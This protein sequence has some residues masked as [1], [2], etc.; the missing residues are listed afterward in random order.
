MR[1]IVGKAARNQT[2]QFIGHMRHLEFNPYWNLPASI[3]RAEIIP[4]QSRDAR[5]LADHDM[6]L[7]DARG[8]TH[9][10]AEDG[11]LAA[12]RSG[13]LRVRQRPG[14]QNPLGAVKFALP[15][16]MDIYLHGTPARLLFQ[17]TRRDYSHGCIRLEDPAALAAFVLA[18]QPE[19]TAE[20][21]TAAM[22][23]GATRTVQLRKT[24]PV[25]LF[26]ATALVD[27][28]GRA[29]FPGDVY[30]LDAALERALATRR[31]PAQRIA[32][33]SQRP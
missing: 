10:P 20:A 14:T 8:A 9:A 23:P 5:Y 4:A 32:E 19:W 13:S 16:S 25:I 24:V 3:V 18:D 12:M 17:A 33:V 22:A 26:Y 7:V 27:D 11:A 31:A 21:I 30:Q 15:N 28:R 1:V 29:L 6:E 2:P